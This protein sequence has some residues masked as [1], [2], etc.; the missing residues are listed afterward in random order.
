MKIKFKIRNAIA[1]GCLLVSI[2]V[3]TADDGSIIPDTKPP[4][5][6]KIPAK[7]QFAFYVDN[8]E[9]VIESSSRDLAE[10]TL[11]DVDSGTVVFSYSSILYPEYRCDITGLTGT[12]NLIVSYGGQTSSAII[13]L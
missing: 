3:V 12:F 4:I 8:D 1:F 9:L 6:P 5:V 11:V 13:I 10:I 7:S 2:G